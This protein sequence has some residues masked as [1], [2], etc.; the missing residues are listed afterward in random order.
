MVHASRPQ[1]VMAEARGCGSPE[2]PS[3][4][5][6]PSVPTA[7]ADS[8]RVTSRLSALPP[9]LGQTPGRQRTLIDTTGGRRCPEP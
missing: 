1:D 4:A 7:G 6:A 8:R 5:Y 3:E 2:S 9:S